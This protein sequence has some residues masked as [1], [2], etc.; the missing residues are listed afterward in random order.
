M[1]LRHSGNKTFVFFKL[2]IGAALLYN[3]I[4]KINYIIY[5]WIRIWLKGLWAIKFKIK[6]FKGKTWL[7]WTFPENLMGLSL[8]KEHLNFCSKSIF[9]QDIMNI[10]NYVLISTMSCWYI[11]MMA[12]YL[13][14]CQEYA[15]FIISYV[16]NS[17]N[18]FQK[19]VK[20]QCLSSFSNVNYIVIT[21]IPEGP[22][23][24]IYT[25]FRYGNPITSFVA[26]KYPN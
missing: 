26:V 13:I 4:V 14:L 21:S 20:F 16:R 15:S 10:G 12:G 2:C 19:A 23:Y 5:T 7:S 3:A 24:Q 9:K 8:L 17:L 1:I 25:S 11:H 22:L 18:S 6:I